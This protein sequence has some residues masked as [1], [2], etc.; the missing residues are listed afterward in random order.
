MLLPICLRHQKLSSDYIWGLFARLWGSNGVSFC[1]LTGANKYVRTESLG[2]V[3]RF[4]KWLGTLTETITE[5]VFKMPISLIY[6]S[7]LHLIMTITCS[8]SVFKKFLTSNELI[9]KLKINLYIHINDFLHYIWLKSNNP[10]LLGHYCNF[11][12]DRVK[13]NPQSLVILRQEIE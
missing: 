9:Y 12:E 10:V 13:D 1:F 6:V 11:K 8:Y 2:P 5:S 4:D 3:I 7:M